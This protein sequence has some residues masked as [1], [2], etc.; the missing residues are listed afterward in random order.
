MFDW[1]TCPAVEHEPGK[2]S[3]AWVF[4]ATR[5]PVKA[6]SENL[7]SGASINDFIAW[8][9][10]VTREMMQEVLNHAQRCS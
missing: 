8:F 9:T 1:S 2:V 4:R 5:V 6:L 3:G 7:E 10:G